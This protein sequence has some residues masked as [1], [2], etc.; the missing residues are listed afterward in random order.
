MTILAVAIPA[1]DDAAFMDGL[2]QLLATGHRLAY[3]LL[4]N[5]DEAEDAVQD[6]AFK[7]WRGR[8]RFRRE[9]PLRPWFLTIVANECRQR[10]RSRWWS[11][12]KVDQVPDEVPAADDARISTDEL[13]SALR[14]LAIDSRLVLVLRYYIDLRFDEMGQ[15]LG[16]SPQAAKSRTHRA[17]QQLRIQIPE[18]WEA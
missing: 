14:R 4:R 3:A 9:A 7:A 8:H 12:V 18:E 1:E 2:E 11:V 13:R 15:I 6:A 16:C 10:R 17:L 5:Q